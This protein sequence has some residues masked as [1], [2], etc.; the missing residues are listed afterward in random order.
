MEDIKENKIKIV[1]PQPGGQERFT[2]SNVDVCFFG[3]SLGGGK[4]F[5]A[6]LS[7]AEPLLDPGFRGVFFRR[8]YGE[9]KG[10]GGVVDLFKEAFGDIVH[11]KISDSPRFTFDNGSYIEARQISDETPKKITETFRGLQ[12]DCL[13]FEEL[14]TFEWYTFMYIMTRARGRG[15]WTGKV[16]ATLN[17]KRSHWTRKWL[18]WYIKPDGFPDPEKDGI[19]RYFFLRGTSVDDLV[20]G[21]TKEEVYEQC[22]PIID[23]QMEKLGGDVKYQDMIKSFTFYKGSLAEN[24][25][26]LEHNRGYVGNVAAAGEKM[27]QALIEG[28]FNVDLQEDEEIPIPPNV[29]ES[30]FMNDPRENNDMWIT[31]DLADTGTDNTIILVWNGLHI[32]DMLILCTSTPRVNADKL[33]LLAEKWDIPDSHIIFDGIRAV[34]VNDYIEDAIPFIS[35]RTSIGRYGRAFKSLKDECYAR[36]IHVIRRENLSFSDKIANSIYTHLKIS[37]PIT[38]KVE[39]IEECS[40]VRF[41]DLPGGRKTLLN[42]KEMNQMLGKG[43]SMDLL[44]PIAMRMYPLLDYEY[45]QELIMTA[46][47][48]KDDNDKYTGNKIN[49]YSDSVWC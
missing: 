47:E 10:A 21:D 15:K 36:L 33:K 40:V 32:I 49:V 16:R 20:W 46:A 5:G 31:A 3:G 43:R 42:K 38:V 26:L 23:R 19:V 12:A 7:M 34:Y 18:D 4:T 25:A 17:P 11:I 24:K 37:N 39:F 44:D 41:K 22:K 6:I 29:A 35:Y 14:T 13:T 27:A 48:R 28:N 8:T 9:L 2:R 45:G 1:K 30:V